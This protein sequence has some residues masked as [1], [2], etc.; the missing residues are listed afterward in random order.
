MR[1][2]TCTTDITTLVAYELS[3][4]S[5]AVVDATDGIMSYSISRY[6]LIQTCY[7]FDLQY[8]L[9]R[10]GSAFCILKQGSVEFLPLEDT[11]TTSF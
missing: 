2:G 7:S 8:Q 5:D 4:G 9:R 3:A 10:I 11:H 6:S 1:F